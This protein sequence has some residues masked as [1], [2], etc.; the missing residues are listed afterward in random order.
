MNRLPRLLFI[1]ILPILTALPTASFAASSSGDAYRAG[2]VLVKL[3]P[4]LSFSET[5]YAVDRHVGHADSTGPLNDLLGN[6]GAYRAEPLG[7]GSDIYRVSLHTTTD[8]ALLAARIAA[9]PAVAFAEPNYVRHMLRV[10]N[11][12]AVPQ[13][14]ALEKIQAF[15]AWEITTGGN[16]V[17]AVLDTGV[18][19]SH[20]DLAGK[21]L[22]GYNAIQNS[23]GTEDNNGHGTAVSGLIAAST[24][25]GTGVA[26]MCWG[27]QILPIKVLSARGGG[28]D[29]S[30]ARGVRWAADNGAR[31]INMSLGGS[32]DS[33]TLREAIEYAYNR[34]VLIVASSGNE[35]QQGNPVNYPAAYPQVVAVGATGN[36]DVITGFSN[37]GDYV[38][39]AAPGVGLWTTMLGDTYGPPNGTSFSSPYVAGAAGLILSIRGDLSNADVACVLRASADDKG[40]PGKDPEYGWGRL[41]AARAL[42][43]A[44]SYTTCPLD[45]SAPQPPVAPVPG[46]APPAFG[47]VSPIPSTPEQV[48]FPETQH[49]L[50]GEF[51][52]YW[53]RHGGLPIF[54]FPI[55]E[56]FVEIGSDGREYV[57]QYFERHRFERH[58]ENAVPYNVQLS[59]LGDTILQ[60][61]GRD[62][63]T[64]PKSAPTAGCLFFEGTGHSLCEPF[65]SYWS[66]NGLEFDGR[67][68]KSFDESMA[69]FGQPL[70]AP[71]VE[72]VSPGVNVTVQWFERARLEDHGASGVLLGLLSNELV[73]AR[74]WR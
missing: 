7:A 32:R 13:Q 35:G 40:A 29:A 19:T 70:S 27:C 48:Y 36:T 54:G 56:E 61:Q 17:I 41:N 5:A 67:S 12:P 11:D 2:E 3:Q 71:Q 69:L 23:D 21:I 43:L 63:F 68:G 42:Q 59:R 55:S 49:T 51:K 20:P 16:V 74:G 53:E 64:F 38:S 57:V 6:L 73:H 22:S 33:Q 31:I 62:W 65:L 28:D 66:S 1:L 30:V 25:N 72:A 8:A 58:P 26:G 24:D 46:N 18:S 39:L 14:W 15:D 9:T 45:Q 34:G 37:T 52:R 50:Q 4:G 44:Q 47:S 10:P 60:L